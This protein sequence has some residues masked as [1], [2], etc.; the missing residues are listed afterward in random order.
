MSQGSL[1]GQ[2]KIPLAICPSNRYVSPKMDVRHPGP[3]CAALIPVSAEL[4]PVFGAMHKAT[5]LILQTSACLQQE[6]VV[7]RSGGNY[8]VLLILVGLQK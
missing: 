1:R 8:F 3:S 6:V 7:C 2:H 5:P 4:S